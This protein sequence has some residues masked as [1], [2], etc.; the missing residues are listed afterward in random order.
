MTNYFQEAGYK[1]HLIGKWHLGY[2]HRNYTPPYRGIDNFYGY[3][4]GFLDYFNYTY[5]EVSGNYTPGYDFRR[6]KKVNYDV[7]PGSYVTDLLTNEALDIIRNHDHKV[8]PLFMMLNHLAPHTGNEY[9]P[10]QAPE[11]EIEKFKFIKD[12]KR[13]IYAGKTFIS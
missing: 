5:V 12:P 9:N 8:K 6:N 10:L 2:F 4:N 1:T 11:D 7:E 3:Y 13:K